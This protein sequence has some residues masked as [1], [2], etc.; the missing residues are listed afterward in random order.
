MEGTHLSLTE[1]DLLLLPLPTPLDGPSRSAALKDHLAKELSNFL[2]RRKDHLAVEPFS[3][4][5]SA[6]LDAIVFDAHA[7]F[8]LVRV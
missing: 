4:M 2:R 3:V 6:R 7:Y 5:Q 8:H 1:T